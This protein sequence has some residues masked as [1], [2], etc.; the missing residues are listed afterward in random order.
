M[1]YYSNN[2]EIQHATNTT[3]PTQPN[4]APLGHAPMVLQNQLLVQGLVETTPTSQPNPTTLVAPLI[5][6]TG[7]HHLL[8]L[9]TEEVNL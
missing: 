3:A 8:A 4:S 2:N 1:Y 9:T 5:A 6:E 7:V